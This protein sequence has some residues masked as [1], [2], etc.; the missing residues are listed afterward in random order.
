MKWLQK[1][2]RY[3]LLLAAGVAVLGFAI[4]SCGKIED[5]AS[6][7]GIVLDTDLL[8]HFATLQYVDA[9]DPA[10]APEGIQIEIL[11]KDKDKIYSVLGEKNITPDGGNFV[12]LGVRKIVA[13]DEN[14]P[15][16]FTI[17]VTAAGYLPS[18]RNVTLYNLEDFQFITI[19]LVR[20]GTD[21]E[22]IAFRTTHLSFG[23]SGT[24]KEAHFK[25]R[26]PLSTLQPIEV[27]I[28]AQTEAFGANGQKLQGEAVVQIGHFDP[29]SPMAL[30]A[31]PGELAVASFLNEE[32]FDRGPSGLRPLAFY[33][34]DIYV[35]GQEAKTFSQPLRVKVTFDAH[36]LH[37]LTGKPLQAGDE[38]VVASFDEKAAVWKQEKTLAV[39]QNQAG[40]LFATFEQA[41]LSFWF[42]GAVP[43][44]C[45]Y[46]VFRIQSDIPKLADIFRTFYTELV[47]AAT[48]QPIAQGRYFRFYNFERIFVF[49][50]PSG[51][52]KMRIW[53]GDEVCKDDMLFESD[54]FDLCA[55]T[56]FSPTNI[57]IGNSLRKDEW[58]EIYVE[59][60]GVCPNGLTVR[61]TLPVLFKDPTC[62]AYT[63]LGNMK[64]GKGWTTKLRQGQYYDFAIIYA[65]L[66]RR[67]SLQ[68]PTQ[69]TIINIVS[70]VYNFTETIVVD[71]VPGSNGV[72]QKLHLNYQNIQMPQLACDEYLMYFNP[73]GTPINPGNGN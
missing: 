50:P 37:P 47:D 56:F 44:G 25:S 39:Q 66:D 11:G 55:G 43:P 67:I 73:D 28:P 17:K 16:E 48:D 57:D 63:L 4:S 7:T 1:N 14:D 3:S 6:E 72:G 71:Y 68:V 36:A 58:I 69:D 61:P 23:A 49:F 30:K 62:P 70:P 33:S 42:I 65:G 21:A 52:V 9:S 5:I 41:H 59:V 2:L 34:L 53:D 27:R 35:A 22:G 45:A 13:V 26:T 20:E 40:R 15:L 32:G 60:S 38:L 64:E 8:T 54:P 24:P 18:Y 51:T 29:Y 19:P 46:T 10:T 31:F 12:N